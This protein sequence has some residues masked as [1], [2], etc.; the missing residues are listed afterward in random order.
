MQDKTEL[1]KLKQLLVYFRIATNCLL[2][3]TPMY[4]NVPYISYLAHFEI[5]HVPKSHISTIALNYVYWYMNIPINKREH[6]QKNPNNIPI[7]FFF[8]NDEIIN[9]NKETIFYSI[10]YIFIVIDKIDLINKIKLKLTE[11]SFFKKSK[12]YYIVLYFSDKAVNNKNY[13]KNIIKKYLDKSNNNLFLKQFAFRITSPD[14]TKE[15]EKSIAHNLARYKIFNDAIS[16]CNILITVSNSRKN[17]SNSINLFN[18]YHTELDGIHLN[19]FKSF[20]VNKILTQLTTYYTVTSNNVK[21]KETIENIKSL[22]FE[23][24]PIK[25]MNNV[26]LITG[27]DKEKPAWYYVLV[28]P[29]GVENFCVCLKNEIIHLREHGVILKSAYGKKPPKNITKIIK[30]EYDFKDSKSLKLINLT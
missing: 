4:E 5:Y 2:K 18:K 13:C 25:N 22:G 27:S 23:Y 7:N 30:A 9:N 16:L 28:N 12:N 20:Y 3:K 15:Y 29:D 24:R 11:F 17:I 14:N 21:L 1:E 10:A 19:Y 26:Y 6:K 8:A